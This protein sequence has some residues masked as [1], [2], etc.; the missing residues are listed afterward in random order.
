MADLGTDFACIKDFSPDLA[1][2]TG[3]ACLAQAIARRLITPRGGLIDDPNYGYDLTQFVNDDLDVP[4]L[5][6]IEANTVA[7]CN[8]DERVSSTTVKLTLAA[9][10]LLIV[11]VS[12]E[13]SAGPFSLVLSVTD[14][15]IQI[16][17]GDK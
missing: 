13:D 1:L 10:G 15:T 2:A 14:V 12:L 4:D 3:R 8:K 11:T 6:R 16:L 9:S 17:A 5:A 7:E